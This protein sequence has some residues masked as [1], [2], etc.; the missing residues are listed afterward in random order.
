MIKKQIPVTIITGYLGSG[1]TTLINNIIR[2]Y[3]AKR[4]AI[5]V[6]E[7]GDIGIDGDLIAGTKEQIYELNNGCICCSIHSDFRQTIEGLLK[8][9]RVFD[10]L[11]IET[12]GI[13]DPS[14]VLRAFM[15]AEISNIFKI[16]SLVCLVDAINF[17]EIIFSSEELKLQLCLADIVLLNKSGAK[18]PQELLKMKDVILSISP[19][20][21]LFEV[22]HSDISSLNLLD[23][24]NYER[25]EIEKQALSF[26]NIFSSTSASADIKLLHPHTTFSFAIPG[27]LDLEKFNVWIENFIYQNSQNIYRIKG[28]LSFKEFDYKIVFQSV[29]D[30]FSLEQGGAWNEES[31]FCKLVFIGKNIDK[32][33]IE[34]GFYGLL[35][36]QIQNISFY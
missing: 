27:S 22:E 34:H 24:H 4:F 12:T 28:I 29:R 30:S 25:E 3:P 11:L 7:F 6:N 31:R 15:D 14:T 18:T 10:H 17:Q 8:N 20:A 21:I 13:A 16:Q 2:Q 19:L 23:T 5:I 36:S 9:G 1:K 35:T 32:E 26:R 33:N